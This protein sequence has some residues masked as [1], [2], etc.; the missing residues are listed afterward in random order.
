MTV[1]LVASNGVCFERIE[2]RKLTAIHLL[3]MAVLELTI[4]APARAVEPPTITVKGA[5]LLNDATAALI[6]TVNP[7]GADT[8]FHFL[9]GTSPAYDHTTS[10]GLL[11][12]QNAEVGVTNLLT[13][14]SLNTI[15]HYQLV[16]TNSAGASASSDMTFATGPGPNPQAPIVTVDG[17]LQIT[18]ADATITGT[19]NPNGLASEFWV[20]WGATTAYGQAGP[21][22]PVGSQN[23]S[24]AVTNWMIG[25]TPGTLYHYRL[26]A[27][28]AAG[29][30]YSADLSLTTLSAPPLDVVTEQAFFV[31]TN[32]ARVFGT[33]NPNG[34]AATYYFQWGTTP[35][36]GN[37]STP[38][39]VPAQ[40]T[41][42]EVF[43]DLTNL[44]PGI[45]YHYRFVATNNAGSGFGGDQTFTTLGVFSIQ[46][47]VF[48]YAVANGLITITGYVG[49]GGNV[50]I[51]GSI[52]GLPVTQIGFRAFSDLTSLTAVAIPDSVTD[53]AY[54]AFMF[55]TNLA[56]LTLGSNIATIGGAAFVNCARLTNVDLPES[57]VTFGG[58]VFEGTGLKSVTLPNN[59]RDLGG[60][61][62]AACTS[63][64]SVVLSSNLTSVG[65]FM[66]CTKLTTIDIPDS[67]TN[68][69]WGAFSGCTSLTNVTIGKSV[70]SIAYA[71]FANC[72]DLASITIPASTV[73]ID[74]GLFQGGPGIVSGVGAINV[75][76]LNST[77]SSVDGVLFDKT[78]TTLIVY[79]R[80]KVVEN[81]LMPN[82]VVNIGPMA[83][84]NCA[85]LTGLTFGTNVVNIFDQAFAWC[86]SLTSLVLPDSLTN[87]IDGPIGRGGISGV[88]A[89]CTSLTNVTIDKGLTYLGLGAFTLCTNLA[90]VYFEGNAPAYGSFAMF[91]LG[92]FWGAE[93]AVA[94]YLPG[95]TGWGPYFA[96][97]VTAL[98]SPQ[99]MAPGSGFGFPDKKFG[100]NV[101][102]P[103]GVTL[104]IEACVDLTAGTWTTLRTCSL[105]NGLIYFSDPDQTNYPAR[106]YRVRVP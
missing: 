104:V 7:N 52:N 30:G 87:I 103:A 99:P 64:E 2:A 14:L 5:I 19:V 29:T 55:C 18:S 35:A 85:N 65:D 11:P 61:S 10:Y 62:F 82:S 38:V 93:S 54:G 26:V 34:Q 24:V 74:P 69:G 27:T 22:I 70:L 79:P 67:V 33:F 88:F 78:V 45:T 3:G 49:P 6:G 50:P 94:Y 63:L 15:Y 44:N 16:A 13:G 73:N 92:P 25:L 91:G 96:G 84:Y 56:S 80:G 106:F 100:F 21:V 86:T 53:M 40:F 12:A 23:T 59:L 90:A 60:A 68:I 89:W 95:T 81:Y 105:T 71:A 31:T 97:L 1:S 28:N 47:H 39:T 66:G 46:G 76:P 101:S 9:W 72:S 75:D 98:W 20:Q 8:G 77:F 32:S 17:P 57:L 36:Y 51:P 102:G 83:F 4:A 37:V 58:S 43:V 42:V 41:P 48:T